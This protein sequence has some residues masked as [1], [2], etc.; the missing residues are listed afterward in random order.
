MTKLEGKEKINVALVCTSMN[1]LGG[2]NTHL[3]NIYRFFDKDDLTICII[4]CSRIAG[5]LRKFMLLEGV[6]E[7][8]LFLI[9]RFKKLLIIP[10]I[11][12]LRRIYIE[13]RID[14]VHTFQIQSDILGGMAAYFSG[15]RNIISQHESKIIE[16]NISIIK[17]LFYRLANRLVN[18]WFKKTI[19]V[20]EGL[21]NELVSG[22]FR[23]IETIEVVHLGV[24]IPPYY[25][26]MEF[27]FENLNAGK[28]V[29]GTIARFSREKSL[30]RI[31]ATVP[32]VLKEFP[33]ARFVIVGHGPERINLE[34]LIR[35]LG[36]G[37]Q[38][39]LTDNAWVRPF[40]A[41]ERIDLFVMPSIREGCPNVLLQALA[42]ARPVIASNIDGIR[43]I[44]ENEKNGILIDTANQ[45][46][47]AEKIIYLCK[48]PQRAIEFGRNGREKI[49]SSF[50]TGCEK[51]KIKRIYLEMLNRT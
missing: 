30:D 49:S 23:T 41:L 46:L 9:P 25:K 50:T 36:I 1:Q 17:R 35:R 43:E 39:T 31:L 38:V 32:R 5:E 33:G 11:L 20:S 48:H 15:K 16:E 27:S 7:D 29:I 14:I 44:V 42:L 8:N 4:A 37:S 45:Q 10:F 40:E 6:R 13:K 34:N 22:R 28:P 18:G 19:V 12:H 26:N 24:D 47:F 3:K 21:K 2:K 51:A